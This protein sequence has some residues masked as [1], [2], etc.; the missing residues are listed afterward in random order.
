MDVKIGQIVSSSSPPIKQVLMIHDLGY[1]SI[2]HHGDYV[3]KMNMGIKKN[4]MPSMPSKSHQVGFS[5]PKETMHG[6]I[7]WSNTYAYENTTIDLIVNAMMLNEV[8]LHILQQACNEGTP[9]F[10]TPDHAIKNIS[11]DIDVATKNNW[12]QK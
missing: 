11:K 9:S 7:L 4:C 6:S 3:L 5:P 2:E 8:V 12:T 1:V 10:E